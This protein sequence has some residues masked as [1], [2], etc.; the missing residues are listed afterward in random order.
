MTR[1]TGASVTRSI[2]SSPLTACSNDS[3]PMGVNDAMIMRRIVA[4][5]STTRIRF[6]ECRWA[7]DGLIYFS[8]R[9]TDTGQVVKLA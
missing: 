7:W 9:L 1:S 2:A 8:A 3:S 6:T 5:S 4:E